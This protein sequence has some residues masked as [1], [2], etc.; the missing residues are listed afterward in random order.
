M[1]HSSTSERTSITLLSNYV[2]NLKKKYLH[3]ILNL[4][5]AKVWK[6]IWEENKEISEKEEARK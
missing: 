5:K 2:V 4:K 3:F 6:K 1:L